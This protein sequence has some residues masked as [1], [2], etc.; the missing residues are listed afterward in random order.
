MKNS[1]VKTGR[2][3][4]MEKDIEIATNRTALEE[5]CP[6]VQFRVFS[7]GEL[8]KE[9]KKEVVDFLEVVIGLFKE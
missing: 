6:S 8:T 7:N 2:K 9:Q 3:K 4:N 5:E 1:P